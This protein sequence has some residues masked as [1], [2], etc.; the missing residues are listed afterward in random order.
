MC[1]EVCGENQRHLTHR[2]HLK[3]TVRFKSCLLLESPTIVQY[4]WLRSFPTLFWDMQHL[5]RISEF[6]STD[7]Q[8]PLPPQ[9][10]HNISNAVVVSVYIHKCGESGARR[11]IR[12]TESNAKC[13]YLKKLTCKGTLRQVFYLSETPSP[14]MTP[15]PPAPPPITHCIRVYREGEGGGRANQRAG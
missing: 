15:S 3:K 9:H 2:R 8:D 14:P 13:R 10:H 6:L 7:I 5:C 4:A 12:L 11:K 1:T